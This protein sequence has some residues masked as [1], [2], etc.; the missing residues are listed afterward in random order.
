MGLGW[1][2]PPKKRYP[3]KIVETLTLYLNEIQFDK[4][5]R[6]ARQE[7][8]SDILSSFVASLVEQTCDELLEESLDGE[9][10][11]FLEV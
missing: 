2:K 7:G 3:V 11:D 5:Q 1:R 8:Q 10:E 6:L 4:L 9:I